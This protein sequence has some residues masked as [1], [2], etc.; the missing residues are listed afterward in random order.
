MKNTELDYGNRK[1]IKWCDINHANKIKR[2][3]A[4]FKSYRIYSLN[5][6]QNSGVNIVAVE[7]NRRR[8]RDER[9]GKG[10]KVDSTTLSTTLS[11]GVGL[12]LVADSVGIA[13]S[14]SAFSLHH[15]RL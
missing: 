7:I 3:T 4:G 1:L 15:I 10:L 9:R 6:F 11:S 12:S 8:T 14:G 13:S 5:T 2:K